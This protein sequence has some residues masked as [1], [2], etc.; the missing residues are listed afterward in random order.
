MKT[1]LASALA[2]VLF[3]PLFYCTQEAPTMEVLHWQ[4]LNGFSGHGEP[5]PREEAEA[6]LDH[7]R[8]SGDGFTYWLEPAPKTN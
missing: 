6:W 1:L 3:L 4:A 8:K 5:L 7:M 2:L